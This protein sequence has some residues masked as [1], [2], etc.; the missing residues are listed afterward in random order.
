[1]MYAYQK[2][3]GEPS[4]TEAIMDLNSENLAHRFNPYL[5][6]RL[7]LVRCFYGACLR[8]LLQLH[9]SNS[10]LQVDPPLLVAASTFYQDARLTSIAS[11]C[12]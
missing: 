9:E 2:I 1:M 8:E 5:A 7:R 11:S 4:K 12:V 3:L 6:S 10:L